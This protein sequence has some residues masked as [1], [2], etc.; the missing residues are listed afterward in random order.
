LFTHSSFSIFLGQIVLGA[1]MGV[2]RAFGAAILAGLAIIP[3]YTFD[4]VCKDRFCQSYKNAGLLQT[5]DLDGWNVHVETSMQERE[6]FRRWLVDCHKASYVPV[7]VNGED[8]F[9]TAEPAAVIAT[10]RDVEDDDSLGSLIM[11]SFIDSPD[12]SEN[13][14][15]LSVGGRQ[16]ASTFDSYQSW[17]SQGSGRQR[18]AL[19]HRVAGQ[20]ITLANPPRETFLPSNEGRG[21]TVSGG[22]A[23]SFSQLETVFDDEKDAPIPL[24]NLSD[25]K[26]P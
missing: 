4:V 14:S 9:L 13:T 21:R 19:F 20:S 2:K 7:C 11:A 22:S 15:P 26:Y 5:S 17:R 18:G 1:I 24:E 8:N 12:R 16:R 6:G 10:E 23:L 25:S 3:T